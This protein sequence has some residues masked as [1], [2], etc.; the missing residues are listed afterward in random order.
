MMNFGSP[1]NLKRYGNAS[2]F[3]EKDSLTDSKIKIRRKK[4]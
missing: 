4:W 2:G 3:F 1:P